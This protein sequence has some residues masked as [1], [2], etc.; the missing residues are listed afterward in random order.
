M[1]WR[2]CIHCKKERNTSLSG[3]SEG[4]CRNC[5]K[6]LIWKPKLIKCK[7]C[8]RMLPHQAKGMC[9]GCYN[10]TFHID[11]IKALNAK[12]YHNIDAETYK[13]LVE[14]C[15][16]CNFSKIIEI[17]HLDHNHNN[18]LPENMVGLCPNHH[19]MLHSK[20]Y[21]SEIFKMLKEKGYS[22]PKSNTSEGFFKKSYA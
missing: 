2:V 3:K 1:A 12:Y 16:I 6:K 5:Y 9:V 17:H 21:Q 8:E 20:K 22:L 7:R 11:K 13:N 19:K 18:S 14:K 15:A 4:L 10:S